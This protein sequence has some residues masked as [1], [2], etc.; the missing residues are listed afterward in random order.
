MQHLN[1]LSLGT[2]DLSAFFFPNGVVGRINNTVGYNL[3]DPGI[4]DFPYKATVSAQVPPSLPKQPVHRTLVHE[5]A[6]G[7]LRMLTTLGLLWFAFSR[8]H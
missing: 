2:G 7:W 6:G 5:V 4:E 3:T 1:V 8:L